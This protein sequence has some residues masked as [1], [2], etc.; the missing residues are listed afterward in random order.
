M[1][2]SRESIVLF[3]I[4]V[5]DLTTT[6]IWVYMNGA[7]EGNPVFAH[8]LSMGPIMFALMKLVMLCAPLFLLEWARARRPLFTRRAA[9][10]TIAAYLL[11]YC[12]GIARLNAQY[13]ATK[14]NL[15]TVAMADLHM[16]SDAAMA[17]K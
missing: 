14:T 9:Q 6:L 16:G 1:R 10:F 3:S 4:G 12:V 7:S 2:L 15:P 17:R 13:F 8:Y 11:L 5:A